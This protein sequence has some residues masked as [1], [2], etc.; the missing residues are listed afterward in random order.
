MKCL[1]MVHD[2]KVQYQ[3]CKDR[4]TSTNKQTNNRLQVLSWMDIIVILSALI[5]S[6]LARISFIQTSQ[7]G[8][9]AGTRDNGRGPG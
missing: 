6:P 3:C 2:A 7:N 9:E 1:P 8:T 5:L 4:N